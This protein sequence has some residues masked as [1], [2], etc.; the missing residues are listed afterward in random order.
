MACSIPSL[1]DGTA[2]EHA[3]GAAP[4]VSERYEGDA[5]AA[6]AALGDRLDDSDGEA[7]T[8]PGDRRQLLGVMLRH[9]IITML[10]NNCWGQKIQNGT[11][12]PLSKRH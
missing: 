2:V 4:A 5:T 9:Q 6:A 1:Q 7:G 10:Q 8:R 3:A 11:T 12:Q